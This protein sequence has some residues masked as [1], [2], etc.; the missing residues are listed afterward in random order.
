M[1]CEVVDKRM[2][3]DVFEVV[4]EE[5]GEKVVVWGIEDEDCML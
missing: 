4:D 3:C 5:M 2:Y 1:F